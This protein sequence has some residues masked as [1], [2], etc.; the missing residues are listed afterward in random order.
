MSYEEVERKRSV[1]ISGILESFTP[2]A[3]S[4]VL[5][6]IA[7]LRQLF[8]FLQINCQPLCFYGMGR[9]FGRPRLLKVVLSSSFF[10]NPI[11]RRASRLKTIPIGGIYVRH[12]LFRSEI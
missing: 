12:T 6:D 7:H 11:I 8:V 4:R 9:I 10:A 1:V 5:H 3:S 2:I